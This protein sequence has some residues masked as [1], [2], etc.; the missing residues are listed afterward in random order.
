[1]LTDDLRASLAAVKGPPPVVL[2]REQL[3]SPQALDITHAQLAC[4]AY[5]HEPLPYP[6]EP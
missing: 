6:E 3:P 4:L 5:H 1:M 2:E